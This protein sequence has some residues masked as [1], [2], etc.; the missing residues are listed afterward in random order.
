MLEAIYAHGWLKLLALALAFGI[1]VSVTGQ[2]SIVQDFDAPLV[3]RLQDDHVLAAPALTNVTVRLRGPEASIRRLDPLRLGVR[4]DL[5]NQP[6]GPHDVWLSEAN[7][8]GVPR[9]V[10]LEFFNPTHVTFELDRRLQRRL[11]VE[12]TVL[13]E[14]PEGYAYYGVQVQPERL[15]VE[16]PEAELENLDRLRTNE[17][18]LNRLTQPSTFFPAA[19]T[20]SPNVRVIDPG[21]L[22]IRVIVDAAPVERAFEQVEVEVL[23]ALFENALSAAALDATLAGPPALLDAVQSEGLRAVVDVTGLEPREQPYI[24]PVRLQFRDAPIDAFA[25]ISVKAVSL[26]EIEVT[27]RERS[28]EA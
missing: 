4:V 15:L 20:D 18:R 12:P 9:G 10:K 7:L 24:L 14:P 27:I 28:P 23:G 5:Q 11:R 21:P 17:I 19:V 6:I 8:S 2:A 22:E 3:L 26:E 16:G 1:W 25:S 13:G